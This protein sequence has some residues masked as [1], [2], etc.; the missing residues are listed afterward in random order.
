MS[1][2]D[3]TIYARAFEAR[4]GSGTHNLAFVENA[5]HNYVAHGVRTSLIFTSATSYGGID[6]SFNFI[7]L[8]I[9]Y[10]MIV[11]PQCR[12]EATEIIIR[13]WDLHEK[14]LL[15][16]GVMGTEILRTQT[17]P[18]SGGGVPAHDTIG[19]SRL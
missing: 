18:L 10:N 16:T 7:V 12:D 13:W 11:T 3:A 1:R 19:R 8:A 9:S 15:T 2:Y 14:K 17:G 5:D 4:E 6:S